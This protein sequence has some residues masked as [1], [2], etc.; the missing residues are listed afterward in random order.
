MIDSYY[1]QSL[2]WIG[3]EKFLNEVANLALFTQE[4]SLM[5]LSLKFNMA[6]IQI[7]IPI[8]IGM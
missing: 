2:V 8:Q 7:P 1:Y 6:I 5:T 3:I 4:S